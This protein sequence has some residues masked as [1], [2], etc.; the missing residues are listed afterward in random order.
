MHSEER[1][2]MLSELSRLQEAKRAA[3][4]VADERSKENCELRQEIERLRAQII[5]MD[6]DRTHN[7]RERD[8]MREALAAIGQV[9]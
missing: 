3:L 1:Q 8:R 5:D 6:L 9:T 4:K 2:K 7:A